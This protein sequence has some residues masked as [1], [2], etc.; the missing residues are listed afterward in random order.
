MTHVTV[1]LLLVLSL[2]SA[3]WAHTPLE[4][5]NRVFA[6]ADRILTDPATE[7]RPLER[8]AAAEKLVEV[9]F[10]FRGAA[11]HALGPRWQ[12]ITAAEQEEFTGLFAGL[13]G[14]LYLWQMASKASLDGGLKIRSLGESV[15]GDEAIVRTAVVRR[16][17]GETHLDYRMVARDKGWKVRDVI[18]G[19]VSVVGNYRAQLDRVLETSSIGELLTQM[20]TKVNALEPPAPAGSTVVRVAAPVGRVEAEARDAGPGDEIVATDTSSATPAAAIVAT[21]AA[22]IV[23]TPAPVVATLAAPVAETPA[24]VVARPAAPIAETPAPAMETPA[25]VV[26][27]PARVVAP[28][29]AVILVAHRPDELTKAYWLRI[30]TFSSVE[31]AGRLAASVRNGQV[32]VAPGAARAARTSLL[33]RVGPFAD[34][35]QAVSRLLELQ[36]KGYNPFMVAESK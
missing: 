30:G 34:A 6:D 27:R 15:E 18:V 19:G 11:A 16:D 26:R 32:V 3:A 29:P 10:D 24:P 5:L 25:P 22:P 31:A 33:V 8:F 7:Q 36:V 13:L 20:R 23:P 17:G 1:A 4:T 21:P 35:D 12:A 14:R 9:A 2:S 28:P